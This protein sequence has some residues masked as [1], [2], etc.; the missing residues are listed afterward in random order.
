MGGGEGGFASDAGIF[1]S[2]GSFFVGDLVHI[3]EL[4]GALVV[5]NVHI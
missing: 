1:G 3:I 4:G 5:V 2:L